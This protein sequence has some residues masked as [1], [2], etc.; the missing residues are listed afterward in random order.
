[1]AFLIVMV[2]MV[3]LMLLLKLLYS[4]LKGV[5]SLHSSQDILALKAIPRSGYDNRRLV[6]LTEKANA[7]GNF[8]I[9]R[10]LSMRKND[11]GGVRYL[12]VIEFAEV[13][14]IHL[15][16]INVGNGGKAVEMSTVLL[17]SLCRA[18]N[19]RELTNARRLDDNSVGLVLLQHLNERLGEIANQRAADTAGVH[20]GDLN[21]RIGKKSAVDTDLAEFVLNKHDLF[22]RVC[23]F[24]KFL[25]KCGFSCSQKAGKYINLCHLSFLPKKYFYK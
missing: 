4:I 13:L 14:H 24:N 19:V 21:T 15:T 11:A 6:V 20:L 22:A 17:G 10:G 3:M 1:M 16:L 9:P 23:L 5:P 18:D 8:L 7:L 2:M 25:Y 12:I